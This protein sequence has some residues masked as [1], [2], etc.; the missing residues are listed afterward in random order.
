L[1]EYVEAIE[2]VCDITG[3]PLSDAALDAILCTE[4]LEHVPNP[5]AVFSNP[6]E[7]C[8]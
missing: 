3:I 4:V 2:H 7:N 5:I 1:V 6:M 8:F